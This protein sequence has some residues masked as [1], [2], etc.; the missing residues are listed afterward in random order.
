MQPGLDTFDETQPAFQPL[1]VVSAGQPAFDDQ[2]KNTLELATVL[3]GIAQ[4]F[5]GFRLVRQHVREQG[6]DH[7]VGI[8]FVEGR[9]GFQ[10]RHR[11]LFGGELRQRTGGRVPLT[12]QVTGEAAI[13]ADTQFSKVLTEDF[14]LAHTGRRQDVIVVCTKGG[15]AM[16]NQVD[17][18][19]VRVIP[20]R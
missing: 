18:A 9:I 3:R 19:H 17:A 13:E 10:D 16:S 2:G 8:E 6:A 1:R 5:E 20:V 15:L 14:C 4:D 11:Q 7:R 12:T